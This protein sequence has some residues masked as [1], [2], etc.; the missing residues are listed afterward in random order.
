MDDM[1][2]VAQSAEPRL[3]TA[4]D[5]CFAPFA[6]PAIFVPISYFFS[7][8][9][10]SL[11]SPIDKKTS[12]ANSPPEALAGNTLTLSPNSPLNS[13]AASA[14]SIKF[15]IFLDV[16]SACSLKCSLLVK[17]IN[18]SAFDAAFGAPVPA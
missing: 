9:A 14:E 13:L 16:N 6:M 18:M 3:S 7:L 2:P 17:T 15:V 8:K 11:A 1:H 12:L 4:T 5:F 10:K